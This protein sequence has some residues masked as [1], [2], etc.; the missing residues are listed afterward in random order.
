LNL[1][2]LP[3]RTNAY[4]V[5]G[6]RVLGGLTIPSRR[7]PVFVGAQAE[8]LTCGKEIHDPLL[9]EEWGRYCSA[10]CH[11]SAGLPTLLRQGA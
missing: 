9:V 6:G 3:K 11:F 7:I 4:A 10:R 2:F 5:P 1:L 8:C